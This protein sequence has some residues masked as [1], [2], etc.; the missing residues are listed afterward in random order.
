MEEENLSKEQLLQLV[1]E[2]KL[3]NKKLKESKKRKA[4]KNI[5]TTPKE[6]IDYWEEREDESDLSVDWA[7]A[8]EICW[9]CGCK[10]KL[11][12]C[13]IIPD[14]LGGKDEPSNLV[15]LCERCHIDAPN[16]ESQTFMWDWIRANGTSF[17][18]TFW[19]LRAQKEYEF[20]YKKSFIEELKDRD[21]LSP[22][23]VAIFYSLPIGRSV[24]HFAH[25]WKNDST[26]AGLLRMRLE[27]Y[28]KKYPNK[29]IKTSKFREKEIKFD[30]MVSK[31]CR[32][33]QE[34]N[35]NV[36]E[37]RTQNPFSITINAFLDI[38]KRRAISIKLGKGN[39]YKACCTNEIN[40]NNN[41]SGDYNIGFG[42]DE[43]EV[44]V[45]VRNAVE[46]FSNEFGIPAKQEYVFTINQIYYLRDEEDL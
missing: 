27:A 25:P 1:Q 28:D 38:N 30:R 20:I 37:G 16:V 19:S 26:N 22:R 32:I 5:K 4:R 9:R 3:E 39:K 45:F 36:W 41:K 11:Q 31:I 44:E 10:R 29:K 23:D 33:A 24:N 40:P 43:D 7:E 35:W 2:L 6:I 12:R 15:L 42:D 34:Y 21:I 17:Y 46:T 13:H 8:E 18:N 14:S